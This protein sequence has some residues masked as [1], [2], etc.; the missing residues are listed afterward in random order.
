VTARKDVRTELD[1]FKSTGSEFQ[2]PGRAVQI[3]PNVFR[4]PDPSASELVIA[5][6]KFTRA[7]LLP[8]LADAKSLRDEMNQKVRLPSSGYFVDAVVVDLGPE[9][10]RL[11]YS[12]FISRSVAIPGPLERP[13]MSR[14]GVESLVVSNVLD[15]L[16][17]QIVDER[18]AV[19]RYRELERELDKAGY[20]VE[21]N[22]V[23]AIAEGQRRHGDVLEGIRST[24]R[25]RP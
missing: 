4:V 16:E 15:I 20:P 12:V 24:V 22:L 7:G 13:R 23:V 17:D 10:G 6:R 14:S 1:K 8:S 11:R 2:K 3:E 9:A 19:Q 25:G 18:R 5:G 21:A